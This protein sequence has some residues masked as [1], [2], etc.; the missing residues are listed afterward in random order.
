MTARAPLRVIYAKLT[1]TGSYD[2][3]ALTPN[4]GQEQA[5]ATAERLRLGEAPS[6]GSFSA[7]LAYLRPSDGGHLIAR[8]TPYPWR[9]ADGREPLMTDLVWVSDEDFARVRSN[10][11]ALVPANQRTFATLETLAPVQLPAVSAQAELQRIARLAP[12]AR[13]FTTF[14]AAVL[15]TERLLVLDAEPADNIELLTLLLP[16]RLRDRLTFQTRAYDVPAP[17]PR[18]TAADRFRATLQRGNWQR[19]FPDDAELPPTVASRLAEYASAPQPLF[20]AHEL[21]ERIATMGNNLAAEAARLIRLADFADKLDKS[22]AMEAVRLIAKAEP[23]EAQV[24][25]AE[26]QGRLQPRAIAEV[27]T[28][29]LERDGADLI[30]AQF[31]EH[32]ASA[33]APSLLSWCGAA[34]NTLL[35]AQRKVEPRLVAL[36]TGQLAQNGEVDGVLGLLAHFRRELAGASLPLPANTPAPLGEFLDA[37]LGRGRRRAVGAAK[38]VV[39]AAAGLHPLLRTDAAIRQLAEAT[40][41]AVHAALQALTLTPD[42]VQALRDLQNAVDAVPASVTWIYDLSAQLLTARFL[43][44]LG[45]DDDVDAAVKRQAAW[46]TPEALAAYAASLLVA[47]AQKGERS[48]RAVR[49]ARAAIHSLGAG[50]L[51]Q[52]LPAVLEQLGVSQLTLWEM[53]GL[54][55]VLV[56]LG[57]SARMA[58]DTRRLALALKRMHT[59]P[60]AL[61]DVAAAVL[62]LRAAGSRING[63]AQALEPIVNALGAR[64]VSGQGAAP[65]DAGQNTALLEVAL[66]LLATIAEPAALRTIENAVLNSA[67]GVTIR[68]R[69]L[70]RAVLQ[71]QSACDETV[72]DELVRGLEGNQHDLSADARQRL[73]QA[74]GL[75]TLQ[76]RVSKGIEHVLNRRRA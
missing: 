7:A 73:R 8:F 61:G 41:E 6:D 47:G 68:L 31:L 46:L 16:P 29:L 40:V 57:D 48:D 54:E 26:L 65:V 62:Q 58:G 1:S 10:A 72:Y 19:V 4:I 45:S 21:Y 30:V 14:A 59:D 69:R 63:S 20:R 71:C 44:Y 33:G 28:A 55:D 11:F 56:L 32:A 51:T 2:V 67:N 13:N 60:A 49:A 24:E 34:A 36:L 66:E 53:A 35:T 9:D 3:V 70:D 64:S 76:F 38:R 74:L 43:D 15:S 27:L 52:R 42:D 37:Q 50:A 75:G 23:A 39:S 17:V 12:R 5:R 22:L 18:I 25:I